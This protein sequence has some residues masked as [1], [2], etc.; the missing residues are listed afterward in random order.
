MCVVCMCSGGDTVC[1]VMKC[2]AVMLLYRES[3][4]TVCVAI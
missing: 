4:L 1:S 2:Y 3:C